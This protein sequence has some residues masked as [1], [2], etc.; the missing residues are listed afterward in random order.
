MTSSPTELRRSFDDA[1]RLYRTGEHRQALAA[2]T[3]ITASQPEMADAWLGRIAC[4]DHAVDTLAGAHLHSRALYRETRRVGLTDGKEL[5]AMVSAPLY[6]TIPVWSRASIALAYA[7]ALITDNQFDRAITVLDHPELITDGAIAQWRQFLTATLYHRTR[8]WPDLLAATA[9]APPAH[10]TTHDAQLGAAVSALTAAA[11]ASLGRF[12]DAMTT[13]AKISTT[14]PF[15]AADVAL[16]RGWCARELGD[17]DSAR[18]YFTHATVN[19]RVVDAAQQALD[20]PTYRLV[21]T[22]A[23]TIA[24][25]TDP[26]DPNTETSRAQRDAAALLAHQQDVLASAQAKLDDV[27]GLD[28]PKEQIAVWR[29]EI[30]IDQILAERGEH[31]S[32]ANENHMVLLGPPGTAKTTFARVVAEILYGLGKITKP[33]VLE[34]SEQDLVVGY[35]S[36]TSAR[37]KEICE[38]ALGGV[39]FID[40]AYQLAPEKEGHTFGTQAIDVLLKFME[41]N[42]EQLVVIVAGYPEEMRRFLK[43]NTGLA[44]RFHHTLTFPSYSPAEIVAIGQHFARTDNIRIASTAW[45]LLEAAA[46]EIRSEQ[47][48]DTKTLL[49][50]AG[51]GRFA[52]NVVRVHCKQ[53][54]ARRLKS[55]PPAELALYAPEDLIVTDEDMTRAIHAAV[56]TARNSVPAP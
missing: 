27:I 40:E 37:M 42:R 18:K 2:F 30:Q 4:G 7:A 5:H 43:A 38:Q 19:G 51:N 44:S 36:Q 41:D 32:T 24:T 31:T 3:A 55:V 28:G 47:V 8:R 16:T 6:L 48:S 20:N 45:P 52:R 50:I 54:R 22:D 56:I 46:T 14:N 21:V 12:D 53:E 35:V 26:W 39:L 11:A 29:T 15:I 1:I 9:V 17:E 49:D 33:D 34:V 13:A 23:D 25:R 10:A